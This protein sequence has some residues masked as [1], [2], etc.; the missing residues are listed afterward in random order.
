MGPSPNKWISNRRNGQWRGTHMISTSG[1]Q[2][3]TLSIA[4]GDQSSN[5]H[6]ETIAQMQAASIALASDHL[7]TQATFLPHSLSVPPAFTA[8]S[9]TW[10][11][12]FRKL[13]QPPGLFYGGFQPTVTHQEMS[14]RTS[15][16]RRVPFENSMIKVSASVDNPSSKP[17]RC[18][19]H[20]GMSIIWCPQSNKLC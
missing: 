20:R 15:S 7:C 5:F 3:A 11:D 10:A 19:G 2:K 14:R 17:S 13:L 4:V 9:Q 12:P 8:S 1:G 18:Q 6:G 16:Q